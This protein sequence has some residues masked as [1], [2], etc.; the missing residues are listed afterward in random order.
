MDPLYDG[1]VLALYW[2]PTYCKDGR[3]GGAAGGFC[4]PFSGPGSPAASRLAIHGLWP[5]WGAPNG[6]KAT[7][8]PQYC[9]AFYECQG[10]NITMDRCLLPAAT[11]RK[12]N[13]S[14]YVV[15]STW[16]C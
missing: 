15:F 3:G 13:S 16:A 1:Y 7:A 12:L 4:S 8:W 6:A 9:D 14:A 11:T 2:A 10:G 5:D